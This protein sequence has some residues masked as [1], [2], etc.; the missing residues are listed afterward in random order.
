MSKLT[1]ASSTPTPTSRIARV[2]VSSSSVPRPLRSPSALCS[3]S[4]RASNIGVQCSGVAL[5][6]ERG[7]GG[8]DAGAVDQV[9]RQ[10][11]PELL[12]WVLPRR[13]VNPERD[14]L[15]VREGPDRRAEAHAACYRLRP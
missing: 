10:I 3:L 12:R 8:S 11:E 6:L 13:L 1:P 5:G 4:A 14:K 7:V 9:I 15:G 2:I